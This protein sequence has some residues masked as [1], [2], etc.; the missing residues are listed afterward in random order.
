MCTPVD[1]AACGGAPPYGPGAF[2]QREELAGGGHGHDRILAAPSRP[3]ASPDARAE[4]HPGPG[5]LCPA[6]GGLRGAGLAKR[7][8][9]STAPAAARVSHV[10]AYTRCISGSTRNCLKL[11]RS[12]RLGSGGCPSGGPGR[13]STTAT[14]GGTVSKSSASRAMVG[15]SIQKYRPLSG[16]FCM[17]N[18]PGAS[19]P[20]RTPSTATSPA[21]RC[22]SATR[23]LGTHPRLT[24]RSSPSSQ[25]SGVTM[26]QPVCT[27]GPGLC[28]GGGLRGP[29]RASLSCR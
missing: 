18:R 9:V 15:T 12:G 11:P 28:P 6:A 25:A 8:A 26:S 17:V 1:T 27:S 29:T 7:R 3:S 20:L 2:A 16:S 14:K 5:G 4:R 24:R 23:S 22:A 13:S 19:P 21:G 10:A